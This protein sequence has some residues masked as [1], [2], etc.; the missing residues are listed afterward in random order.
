MTAHRHRPHPSS[1]HKAKATRQHA[2]GPIADHAPGRQAQGSSTKSLPAINTEFKPRAL[3]GTILIGTLET[4]TQLSRQLDAVGDCEEPLGCVIVN[5]SQSSPRIGTLPGPHNHNMAVLGSLDDLPRI[6]DRLR[7]VAAVVSLP[8]AMSVIR[9]HVHSKL[10]S[11]GVECRLITPLGEVMSS[12]S[13]VSHWWQPRAGVIDPAVLIDRQPR[14]LDRASVARVLGNKRVLITGAGGSI[15]SELARLAAAFKPDML[16]L[17]ERSENA[18]F[19]IDRQLTSMGVPH[20]AML[21]DV[22]DQAGTK[23]L[24]DACQPH[25]VFHTA[26][27]KHVPLMEDHPGHAITN[28][29]FGTKSVADASLAAGVEH[30]VLISTDKAVN[31]SSIMG[32]TKRIAEHYVRWLHSMARKNQ[33][34]AALNT[35]DSSEPTAFSVVRFGNVLGSA[36]SVLPIWSAQIAQGG[37]VTVTDPRMTRYFMTIPEA[38]TLVMQAAAMSVS[39]GGLS[40]TRSPLYVL[41]MGEP[42]RI[43]E[44]AKRLIEQHGYKSR[45]CD[46]PSQSP[47]QTDTIEI[48]FTGIRPGEKLVEELAYAQEQLRSTSH[49]G[50]RSYVTTDQQNTNL[51]AVIEHLDQIRCEPDAS[52]VARLLHEQL[53]NLCQ[54]ELVRKA[55]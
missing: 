15:G 23:R 3:A 4:V 52:K 12:H 35:D 27:H 50:I 11:L 51:T 10:T 13:P 44:L 18:L 26:A 2:T 49:P 54:P 21:H 39:P 36:C 16:L 7:P 42:I 37:P 40:P 32:A 30:F 43:V 8:S 17:V 22:V 19:E 31:P 1:G 55:G 28:N 20:R 48:V 29:V 14:S 47:A 34:Q 41:D 5:Q 38:A 6:C 53:G 33:A 25:V 9:L 46:V 45:L 24:I